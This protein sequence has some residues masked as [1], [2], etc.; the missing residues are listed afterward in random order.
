MGK[1]V[2]GGPAVGRVQLLPLLS[3][4]QPLSPEALV[5]SA[6]RKRSGFPRKSERVLRLTSRR[7]G[8]PTVWSERTMGSKRDIGL[9][10]GSAGQS[11]G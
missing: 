9:R 2:P 4:S 8:S 1:R 5:T 3:L 10:K 6:K 11:T 7:T